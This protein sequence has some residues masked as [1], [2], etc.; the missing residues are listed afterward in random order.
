MGKDVDGVSA[1]LRL[2]GV[3][4]P[5]LEEVV[6][7]LYDTFVL[8]M[9]DSGS[10]GVVD[11]NAIMVRGLRWVVHDRDV[12]LFKNIL[13]GV[14]SFSATGAVLP[15]GTTS[16]VIQG[17]VGVISSTFLICRN[18]VMRGAKLDPL[19]FRVLGELR[20]RQGSTTRELAEALSTAEHSWSEEQMKDEL[21]SMSQIRLEDGTLSALVVCGRDGQWSVADL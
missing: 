17:I 13:A 12:D 11:G 2:R 20:K 8:D 21:D 3:E 5:S 19:Q 6:E 10:L 4:S 16:S 14:G 7:H 1:F 18:L 9:P 15:P